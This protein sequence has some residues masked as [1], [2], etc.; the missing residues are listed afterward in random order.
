MDFNKDGQEDI[1]WRYYGS[2]EIQGWDVVWLMQQSGTLSPARLG[3]NQTE[4]AGMNLLTGSTPLKSYLTPIDVGNSRGTVPAKSSK[5]PLGMGKSLTP[6]SKK[7][8]RNP[9]DNGRDLSP[10][11]KGRTRD[12]RLENVPTLKDMA[13][14]SPVSSGTMEIASLDSSGLAFLTTVLDTAWELAGTGDFNGDGNTDLLWRYYG[15]GGL[16]GWDVIWYMDGTTITSYGFLPTVVD[17]NWRIAGTGDVNGDGKLEI[18]WRYYGSGGLQGWDVIW[19]MNGETITSYGFPPVVT[20]TNWKVD[21]IG[22]FNGDGKA[23]LLW[24]YYGSGGY[25][26]WNVIWYMNGETITSYGFPPMV[27]DLNWKVDG[28]GDFDQDGKADMLWRYYG[29]GGYQGW[30]IVWYMNEATIKSQENLTAVWDTNWR[31]VNR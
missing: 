23:D 8:M 19:Y 27:A 17:T 2:G 11:G 29:S 16:Q 31:I 25:Q 13:K 1:L 22:D 14:T 5:T 21:G 30:N 9:V 6:R 12:K 15:S 20:D 28:T 7:V 4:L 26:G 3:I 10:R 24:R 18:L